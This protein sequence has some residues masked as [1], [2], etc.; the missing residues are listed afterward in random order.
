M[1]TFDIK[2]QINLIFQRSL[3]DRRL[4]MK[5]ASTRA[6]SM[7]SILLNLY[8]LIVVLCRVQL[9][10]SKVWL[11]AH[12]SSH[13]MLL[14]IYVYKFWYR[15]PHCVSFTDSKCK[16]SIYEMLN[17]T[18]FYLYR[19][20]SQYFPAELVALE[21]ALYIYIFFISFVELSFSVRISKFY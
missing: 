19:Y 15:S 12:I 16:I 21:S 3:T 1:F 2:I 5:W 10:F 9:S 18:N 14:R 20:L 6:P 7:D 4:V 17:I 13:T 11:C 8:A